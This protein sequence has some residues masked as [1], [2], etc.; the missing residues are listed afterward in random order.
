MRS[1][2]TQ[3]VE[4]TIKLGEDFSKQLRPGTTVALFGDLGTG[5]T[6]LIK[7]ICRGLGIVEHVASP[8]FTIVNEYAHGSVKVCHVDCY[9]LKSERELVDVGFEEYVAGPNIVLVE[10]ADR[11]PSLL[12]PNRFDIRLSFGTDDRAREILIEDHTLQPA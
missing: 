6:H 1:F 9:R 3:S 5:K 12:P 8:T 4:E 2:S 11:V 10:W 7:G